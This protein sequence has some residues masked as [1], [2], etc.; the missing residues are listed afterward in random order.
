[1][2]NALIILSTAILLT[3]CGG[4]GFLTRKYTKGIYSESISKAS[5][6][7]SHSHK[8]DNSMKMTN[9]ES[10]NSTLAVYS[11]IAPETKPSPLYTENTIVT[12]KASL[13]GRTALQPTQTYKPAKLDLSATK[14]K[15]TNKAESK[16]SGGRNDS[17]FIIMVILCFFP[18]INLIPVYMHDGKQVTMNFWITLLLNLLIFG[19]VIFALLVIFDILSLA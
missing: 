7:S 11:N 2:K 17:N 8:Q 4:S 5:K 13:K 14:K 1:M 3:S 18:F 15:I 16:R 10:H 12:K 9:T 19:G 6:P